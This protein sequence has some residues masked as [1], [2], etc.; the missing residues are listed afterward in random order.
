[1]KRSNTIFAIFITALSIGLVVL[2]L[3]GALGGVSN[4]VTSS[5][6]NAQSYFFLRV[7]VLKEFFT[8]PRDVATLRQ[9]NAE[10]ESEVSK[11]QSQVVTL[12]KAVDEGKI[13]EAL[14]N[15][16]RA[17][18]E[19]STLT[20]AVIGRDPSPFL[21]YL[22]IDKGSTD[23]IYKGMPVINDQGLVGRVDAVISNA[24]RVQLITDSASVINIRLEKSKKDAILTGSPNGE[25][26]I[27][28][29]SQDVEVLPGEVIL[30]SGISGG[31]PADIIVGQVLSVKKKDSD[32]FQEATVQPV[33]DFGS[34]KIVMVIRDFKPVDITPL[35]SE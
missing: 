19:N 18:P 15:Y 34:L 13:L 11:L 17:N 24:A 33:V 20:A 12:Q 16:A 22:I 28:L 1:M 35:I 26:Q 32:L 14:V 7:V 9:R 27:Q 25:L 31:Y 2:A 3:S 4:A 5:L 21:R 30:T 8:I 10:L 23:G 29:L 6:V